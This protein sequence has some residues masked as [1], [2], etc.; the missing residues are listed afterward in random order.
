MHLKWV[1]G[2]LKDESA[3]LHFVGAAI[4][5][6][7]YSSLPLHRVGR[8]NNNNFIILPWTKWFNIQ[9]EEFDSFCFILCQLSFH[10]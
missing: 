2:S 10:G 4:L 8:S 5:Q 1:T 9:S 3:S 6:I 7:T